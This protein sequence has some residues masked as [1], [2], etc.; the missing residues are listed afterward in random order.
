MRG[1]LFGIIGLLLAVLFGRM[2]WQEKN[3]A[4]PQLP[5]SFLQERLVGQR[6]LPVTERFSKVL[7]VCP[8]GLLK[9]SYIMGWTATANYSLD[10]EA[11]ELDVSDTEP[12]VITARAP[13]LE[14]LNGGDNIIGAEDHFWFPRRPAPRKHYEQEKARAHE[15]AIA[16][17]LFRLQNDEELKEQAASQLRGLL[18]SL[19]L[20]SGAAIER[21]D[22]EIADFDGPIDLPDNPPLCEDQPLGGQPILGLDTDRTLMDSESAGVELPEEA[23]E[24][25]L[26]LDEGRWAEWLAG[27]APTL[28]K[29]GHE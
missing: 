16:G 24:G 7:A 2:W 4:K 3:S 23:E 22:V 25:P 10:L 6:F 28:V 21:I 11:L 12:P 5:P 13:A 26:V 27:P 9:G 17:A 19:L 20:A 29:T 15:I 18:A 14:L 8:P 1:F